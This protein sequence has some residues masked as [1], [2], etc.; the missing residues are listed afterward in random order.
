MILSDLRIFK[1]L[2]RLIVVL[3]LGVFQ[4]Q[5]YLSVFD[6]TQMFCF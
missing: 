1:K 3:K 5:Q 2:M 4:N 6:I